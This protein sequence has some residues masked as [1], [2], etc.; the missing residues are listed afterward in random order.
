MDATAVIALIGTIIG[1]AGT[2][3]GISANVRNR[4]RVTSKDGEDSGREIGKILTDL[5]Y[6][7]LTVDEIKTKVNNQETKYIEL[8]AKVTLLES[9]RELCDKT[10]KGYDER[11]RLMEKQIHELRSF[12]LHE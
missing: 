2:I 3:F 11:F 9:F 6:I 1:I 5:G 4:D 10:F 7:K 8:V 12:H